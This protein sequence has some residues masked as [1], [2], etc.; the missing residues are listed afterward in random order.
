[1]GTTTLKLTVPTVNVGWIKGRALALGASVL[2]IDRGADQKEIVI[3]SPKADR[4]MDL[5]L[6]VQK[7]VHG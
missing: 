3:Q 6:E 7:V 5:Y 1:M 2:V 4:L